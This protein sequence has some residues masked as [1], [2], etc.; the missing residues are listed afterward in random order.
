MNYFKIGLINASFFR[1]PRPKERNG[2][3][4]TFLSKDEFLALEK[5]GDLLESG[6]YDGNN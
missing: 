5:S 4:Y 6:V 3:D 2:I 1:T